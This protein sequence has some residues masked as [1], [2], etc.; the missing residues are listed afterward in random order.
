MEEQRTIGAI[1]FARAEQHSYSDD[2]RAVAEMIAQRIA[3][4]ID[5]AHI[6]RTERHARAELMSLLAES[7]SRS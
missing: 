1:T 6:L 4:A 5:N 3:I 7:R 2:D